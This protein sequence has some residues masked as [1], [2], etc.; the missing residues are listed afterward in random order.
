MIAPVFSDNAADRKCNA[1]A[2]YPRQI[3]VIRGRLSVRVTEK[4]GLE[5]AGRRRIIV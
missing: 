5:P 4:W 2:L 1:C 3:G